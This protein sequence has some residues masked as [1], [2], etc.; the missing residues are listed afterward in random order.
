MA[1]S[2]GFE[3]HWFHPAHRFQGESV[4]LTVHS[5]EDA[6]AN[7]NIYYRKCSMHYKLNDPMAGSAGFEPA[8][9]ISPVDSLAVN[10][11]KPLTQLP[12]IKGKSPNTIFTIISYCP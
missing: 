11:F 9:E 3:P 8:D 2:G 10:W 12:K 7:M 1:E 6:I 4:A 5:P